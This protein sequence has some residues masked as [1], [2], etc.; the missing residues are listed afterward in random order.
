MKRTSTLA[1]SNGGKVFNGPDCANSSEIWRG[2]N[3]CLMLT[4][5]SGLSNGVGDVADVHREPLARA[6]RRDGSG[7][8]RCFEAGAHLQAE[9]T[10]IPREQ[11]V[12]RFETNPR[13][14]SRR[15][16][17][18]RPTRCGLMLTRKM[19]EAPVVEM[20]GNGWDLVWVRSRN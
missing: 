6:A 20:S 16:V 19:T 9:R 4:H 17:T 15:R 3:G 14:M 10:V 13:A 7:A 2:F 18:D 5:R 1:T 11:L 12:E 8:H